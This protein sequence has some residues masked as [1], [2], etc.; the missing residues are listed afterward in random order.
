[1]QNTRVLSIGFSNL[2]FLPDWN[3]LH[4]PRLESL[5]LRVF[6]PK[7]ADS[8]IRSWHIPN[9]QIL[10]IESDW[11]NLWLE[12]IEK[13]GAKIQMLE[14]ILQVPEWSHVIQLPVLKE[15]LVYGRSCIPYKIVAPK[16]ERFCIFWIDGHN[17][18]VREDVITSVDHARRSFPTLKR[19]RLRGFEGE[20]YVDQFT[21]QRYGLTGHDLDEWREA[22]IWVDIRLS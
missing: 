6:T 15:L 1:M 19:L 10:S 21:P 18:T 16:L 9:I 20:S 7:L 17:R 11:P 13:W 22:G 2:Q 12:F 4:F 14:L 3:T 5:R 8:L